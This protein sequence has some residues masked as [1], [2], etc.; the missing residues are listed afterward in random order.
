[1]PPGRRE[2]RVLAT[3]ARL[4]THGL[5][6]VRGGRVAARLRVPRGAGL[7]SAFWMLG[8]DVDAVGWPACGEIDVVEH[9]TSDPTAAHGTLHGPG[10]CGLGGG[11]GHRHDTG[12]DLAAAFHTFAVDWTPGRITW[13]VDGVATSTLTPDEVPGPW[14]FDHPFHL[15]LDLAVGGAWPGVDTDAP[16]LPATLEV[17]WVRVWDRLPRG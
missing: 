15:L 14:P 9:V 3:S 6:A 2:G 7:W 13:S 12:A 1:M 11:I 17:A 5:V 4:L 16:T 8:E 10:Y